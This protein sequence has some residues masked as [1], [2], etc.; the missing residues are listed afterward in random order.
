[1]GYF[2]GDQYIDGPGFM[3]W[4]DKFRIVPSPPG[5]D[6]RS[7]P[8]KWRRGRRVHIDTADQILTDH[9]YHL[10]DLPDDIW[11]R[12]RQRNPGIGNSWDAELRE[13]VVEE[14]LNGETA[15]DLRVKYGPSEDTIRHWAKHARKE[16]AA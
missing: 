10:L 3:A 15:L 2:E 13:R 7:V 14:F 9:G 6:T 5:D 4:C 12:Y 1:M 11:H 16:M 8:A